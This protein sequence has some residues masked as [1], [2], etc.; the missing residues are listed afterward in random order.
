MSELTWLHVSDW[1]QKGKDF[2][3]QVMADAI[4]KDLEGRISVSPDLT[5]IDFIVFSG[6]AAYNGKLEEYEATKSEL[7]ERLLSACGLSPNQLFI[8]PGNHDLDRGKLDLVLKGL[9]DLLKSYDLVKE[10][11]NSEE[12]RAK[13]LEPFQA[14]T[15]FVTSYAC[16]EQPNYASIRELNIRGRK[17]ALLGLNSAWTCGRKDDDKGFVFVGEPQVYYSLKRIVDAEIKIAVLH[18]PFDWLDGSDCDHVKDRL[19]KECDFILQGHQHKPGVEVTKSVHGNCIIIPAGACYNRRIAIDPRYTCSYNFV[20]LNID[21]RKGTVFF[22]RW[23]ENRSEWIEDHDAYPGGRFDFTLPKTSVNSLVSHSNCQ[24]KISL[25]N[26]EKQR[27]IGPASYPLP[28]QIPSPPSDFK[29]RDKEIYDILSDFDKGVTINGLRGMAGVGKTA[30]ALVLA[31]RLKGSFPDGQ[32]FLNMRGT[33]SYPLSSADA[34]AKV[35]RAYHPTHR[36]PEDEDELRGLYLSVLNGKSTLL[37]LDNA[38][39]RDQVEHLLPPPGSALIV[40]SRS[41]FILPGLKENDLD[42][43]PPDKACELLLD[44]AIR[45][46]DRADGLA[47]LCG[48]LPLAL[49]N[50]ASALAEKKDLSVTEYEKRLEDR[51]AR[52]KLV[53]ASFSLSYDLLSPLRRK[54]WCRLSVFPEDFDREGGVAILGIA[55]H[56]SLEALSDLV[57]WS[58]VDYIYPMNSEKGRYK[59]HDLARIFAESR[60]DHFERIDTQWHHARHYQKVLS[61]ANNCYIKGGKNILDGLELFDRERV[62]I[63]VG[64]AWLKDTI[65]N[66]RTSKGDKSLKRALQMA[67]SYPR[68]GLT[69]LDKRLH[70][71]KRIHWHE[72]A[73]IAIQKRKDRQ[74]EAGHLRSLGNAY[75]EMGENRKAIEFHEQSLRIDHENRHWSG[76]GADLNNLG[77]AYFDLGETSKA[78]EFYQKALKIQGEIKDG[79]G[80]CNTLS[81]LCYA[82]CSLGEIRKAVEYCEKALAV[83]RKIEFSEGEGLALENMCAIH[84]DL[85]DTRESIEC[86]ELA[87]KIFRDIGDQR[88][89]GCALLDLGRAYVDLGETNKAIEYFTQALKVNRE[90][91]ERRHEGDVLC[92]LGR[93]YADLGEPK[94]TVRC[95][96]QALEIVRKTGSR[97]TEGEALHN[98]GRAYT[99]LGETSRA[100][101]NYEQSLEIARKIGYK[102]IEGSTLFN[103]SIVLNKLGQRE[104]AIDYAKGALGIFEKIESRKTKDVQKRLEEWVG[105]SQLA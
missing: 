97:W 38:A 99:D 105:Q 35:I 46:G 65:Q 7:F 21:S 31:E 47:K 96:C 64:H 66:A 57:N 98:L 15:D 39:S 55:P 42:I 1:H 88:L 78:I 58:L 74:F 13:A 104:K 101:E 25:E 44:I 80:E 4:I 56:L 81:S 71:Q 69:I 95:S 85:G 36:M 83:A 2:D 68:E 103:M 40:T 18:H 30:L 79:M 100:I 9:L 24:K 75:W 32:I 23:S 17:V 63:E 8:V 34:M 48:Y 87:L 70:P 19:M 22:R 51:K 59:L 41:K 5:K 45:I 91:G 73:L 10:W 11:L 14:F 37:L 77:I 86:G 28:F 60:L 72:I 76:E 43:L 16:L 50:A 53:E 94:K 90:I 67:D 84:I 49:R 54:Q 102:R 3:R 89:E 93:A 6:D 82:Y 12:H 20:H 33:S 62:N 29:G 26:V 61:E 92:N 27:Q 52:L